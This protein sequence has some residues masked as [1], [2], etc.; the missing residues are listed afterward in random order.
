M[1]ETFCR[2]ADPRV[3]WGMSICLFFRV[4]PIQG[5]LGV[6]GGAY[7]HV[8]GMRREASLSSN[9]PFHSV[10]QLYVGPWCG[11]W[12]K[13]LAQLGGFP[14]CCCL[15]GRVGGECALPICFLRHVLLVSGFG[16]CSVWAAAEWGV[17]LSCVL[18]AQRYVEKVFL[19]S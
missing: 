8:C 18:H 1:Q 3:G 7:W 5:L 17:S 10:F 13:S 2:G 9:H 11:Q 16:G 15:F 4:S 12:L 6:S 14:P 19:S